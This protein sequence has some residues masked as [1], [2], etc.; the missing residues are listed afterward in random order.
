MSVRRHIAVVIVCLTLCGFGYSATAQINGAVPTASWNEV[1]NQAKGQTVYFNAW[2]GDQA[3]NRYLEWA[4]ERLQEDYEVELR[5]VRVTDISEAV[6]RIIAERTAGRDTDGS[7]DLLWING[8]NFAALKR[9]ELLFGPWAMQLPSAKRINWHNNPTTMTDGSLPTEGFELP[10]GTA[11][12]TFFFDAARVESPPANPAEL[13]AWIEKHPGRFSY[14]QP[15][16]FL[17]SAFLKQ[18]LLTLSESQERLQAPVG[19]QFDQQTEPLWRWLDRA[20][21]SMWRGGRL[22]PQSG[23]AQRDLVAVGELDWMLSYNPSEASRAIRQGELHSGIGALYFDAGALANSH[24]LAIPYNCRACAGA[25]VVANFLASPEAQARKAD[26]RYW[27]DP[28]VLELN[29]LNIQERAYFEKLD[30]G[31]AT[32]PPAKRYLAEPH[33][34]WTTRLE[35]AWLERY[36]R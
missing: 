35:Q 23:P 24:F 9:A 2:G 20:H 29:A 15:P 18:M 26:E 31:S 27:G 1:L 4:A 6:T 8:E 11:A 17:G 34:E 33:P 13:L 30:V 19:N 21:D 28:T 5:H 7:V 16:S 22:F 36:V 25:R 12:L 14:P 3:I 10:W 32:P